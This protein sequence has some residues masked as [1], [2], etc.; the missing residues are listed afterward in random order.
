MQAPRTTRV[1][2]FF[3]AAADICRDIRFAETEALAAKLDWLR[4]CQGQLS[5][6]VT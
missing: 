3:T 2:G 1:E 6:L 4:E 5:A